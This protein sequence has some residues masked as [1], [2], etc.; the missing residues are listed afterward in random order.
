MADIKQKYGTSNQTLTTLVTNMIS[1]ATGSSA[2][3]AEISNVTNLFFDILVQIKVKVIATPSG[4]GVTNVYAIASADA[5]TSYPG[6]PNLKTVLIGSFNTN[7]IATFTSNVMSVAQAFGGFLPE[8]IKIVVENQSG[9]S[10]DSSGNGA[11][12]QGVYA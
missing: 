12:Y 11:F 9:A 1:L 8:R 10:Y 3:S 6:T 5:G 2:T 4:T 7:S